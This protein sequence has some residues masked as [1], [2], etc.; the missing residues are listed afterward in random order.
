MLNGLNVHRRESSHD[1]NNVANNF[2]CRF[3]SSACKILVNRLFL[4]S[5]TEKTISDVNSLK[6]IEVVRNGFDIKF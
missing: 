1:K 4:L 5:H 6:H 2:H 3:T